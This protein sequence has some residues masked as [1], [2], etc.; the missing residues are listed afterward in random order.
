MEALPDAVLLLDESGTAIFANAK[1]QRTVRRRAGGSRRPCLATSGARIARSSISSSAAKP[2]ASHGGS[3][4]SLEF[5]PSTNPDKTYSLRVWPLGA[6]Q[7]ASARSGTLLIF[8]D[9]TAEHRAAESRG[10]FVAHLAHELKTP[11]NVLAM[12]SESLQMSGGAG[13]KRP[14]RSGERHQ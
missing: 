6:G 7:G 12:Y 1:V 3:V 4:E 13:R 9:V 10:E 5:K 2:R 11:L 14:H 8:R